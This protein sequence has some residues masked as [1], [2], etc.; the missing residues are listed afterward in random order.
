MPN[1]VT[2]IITFKGDE[3]KIKELLNHIKK[4]DKGVGSIDFEKIIPMPDNIY[5]GNLG[6]KEAELYGE[7]NWYDWS[8]CNWGTKWNSYGYD[9]LPYDA[10]DDRLTFATAW[11][12]PHPVIQKLAEM[13]PELWIIHEWADEDIGYNCGRK[14]Y[15]NGILDSSYY[16]NYGKES[17]D[18]SAHVMD[19]DLL[20]DYDLVPNAIDSGYICF[21]DE[22]FECVRV[23]TLPAL[24]VEKRII[25]PGDIPRGMNVYY[26]SINDN[27]DII[28]ISKYCEPNSMGSLVTKTPI[29]FGNKNELD[30]DADDIV[31]NESGE[32][33]SFKE[34]LKQFYPLDDLVKG[35]D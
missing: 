27:E 33:I 30:L 3:S 5:R 18:F 35:D 25:A 22:T 8:I 20:N 19:I 4:D 11:S 31:R 26:Y 12:A 6:P 2:N 34:F 21:D 1:H 13:Y 16:P 28:G 9:W 32:K 17:Y 14:T 24:L 7:N 10:N 15:F 23:F 29:E